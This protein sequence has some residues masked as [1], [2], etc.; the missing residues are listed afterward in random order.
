MMEAEQKLAQAGVFKGHD[1]LRRLAECQE[2]WDQQPYGTRLYFEDSGD[3]Y[4]HR[5]VLRAAVKLLDA[6]GVRDTHPTCKVNYCESPEWCAKHKA[7]A[8]D[9]Q[10]SGD[11]VSGERK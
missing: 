4:L 9:R 5:D 3:G 11:S 7:C 1:G 2:F 10:S 6:H 8:H